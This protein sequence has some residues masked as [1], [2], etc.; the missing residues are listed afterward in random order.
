MLRP[1]TYKKLSALKDMDCPLGKVRLSLLPF[2]C[3]HPQPLP[4]HTLHC[5]SEKGKGQMVLRISD[6]ERPTFHLKVVIK[7]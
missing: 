1:L 2:S 6:E 7:F 4:I 5:Y 3:L